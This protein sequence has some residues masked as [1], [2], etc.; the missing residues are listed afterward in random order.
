MTRLSVRQPVGAVL[1]V[2]VPSELA[3]RLAEEAERRGVRLS[4]VVRAA[5]EAYLSRT[6]SSAVT[7]VVEYRT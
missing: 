4:D 1:S 7:Y 3:S 5:I 2:R 6:T